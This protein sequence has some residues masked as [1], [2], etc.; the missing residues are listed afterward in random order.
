MG[1][2]APRLRGAN[3]ITAPVAIGSAMTPPTTLNLKNPVSKKPGQ[4]QGQ[5]QVSS[6][7]HLSPTMARSRSGW[8]NART[9]RVT[10]LEGHSTSPVNRPTRTSTRISRSPYVT[11]ATILPSADFPQ[12]H[13]NSCTSSS[14]SRV[15]YSPRHCGRL[16]FLNRYSRAKRSLL[17]TPSSNSPYA[18]GSESERPPECRHHRGSEAQFPSAEREG[19]RQI[20]EYCRVVPGRS[21]CD[22]RSW[23]PWE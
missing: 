9:K 5:R 23:A 2:P 4:H 20:G 16:Y 17:V 11:S 3:S 18:G 14:T 6:L 21:L 22:A 13:S 19:F 1:F 10:G 7:D 12:A 8:L 15:S